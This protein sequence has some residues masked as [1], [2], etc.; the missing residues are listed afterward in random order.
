MGPVWQALYMARQ[1]A[2]MSSCR[3]DVI[4]TQTNEWMNG[5]ANYLIIWKM[6][7]PTKTKKMNPRTRGD[8]LIFPASDFLALSSTTCSRERKS[9]SG[10]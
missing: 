2:S 4:K 5:M 8:K 9:M 7:D 6:D 10:G 3:R 1:L